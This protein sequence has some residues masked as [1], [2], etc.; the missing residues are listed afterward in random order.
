MIV[1]LSH[2]LGSSN[3]IDTIRRQD[4]IANTIA[5]L[6][7]LITHTAW[8][9]SVPW[10]PFVIAETR[11]LYRP[12]GFADQMRM[13]Q[14]GHDAIAHV[15]GV[16]SPHMVYEQKI[17]RR[18]RVAVIDLTDLGYRPPLDR[19]EDE[20]RELLQARADAAMAAVGS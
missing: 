15:G 19:N 18:C 9:I 10:L 5:W 17:A 8:A 14:K 13:L 11:E 20:I 1:Y 4:N 12:R 6:E 2:S 16:I 7:F 3:G